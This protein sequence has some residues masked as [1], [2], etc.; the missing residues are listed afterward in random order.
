[1][2][3]NLVRCKV[4]TFATCWQL[5]NAVRWELLWEILVLL[6]QMACLLILHWLSYHFV[7]FKFWYTVAATDFLL[8][9]NQRVCNVFVEIITA[10]IIKV[11]V[12]FQ[13]LLWHFICYSNMAFTISLSPLKFPNLSC[14]IYLYNQGTIFCKL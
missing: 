5:C 4:L 7:Q 11:N 2:V 13:V 10:I 6:R 12:C 3:W 14:H 8:P 9:D 1:M